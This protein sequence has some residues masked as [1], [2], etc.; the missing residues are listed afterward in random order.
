MK[1]NII[2]LLLFALTFSVNLVSAEAISHKVIKVIDGDTVYIDFN[3]NGIP[4]QN[5]K[6]RINGVDTFETKLNDSLE[7]QMKLYGLVFCISSK[8]NNM[9]N[10]FNSFLFKYMLS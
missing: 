7:W 3:D 10:A 8:C 6:V 9:R 5:E 2:I 4:E 1:T